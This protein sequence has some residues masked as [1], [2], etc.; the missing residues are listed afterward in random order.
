MLSGVRNLKQAIMPIMW[1]NCIFCMGIFEIP[2]NRP[3][4]FL[5]GFYV[6]FMLTG[7]CI[8]FY[9]TIHILLKEFLHEFSIFY[10]VVAVNILVAILAIIL[11]WKRSENVSCLIKRHSVVDNTLDAL[12]MKTEYQVTY[13]SVLHIIAIWIIGS[14]LMVIATVVWTYDIG[15]VDIICINLVLH[16]PLFINSIVDVTFISF[17]RCIQL[18]FQ[19]TN[20]LINNV[21]LCANESNTFKINRQDNTSIAFVMANYKNHKDKILHLIQTLR[22]L[23]LEIT[24]IGRLTNGAYCILLLLELAVHF[25]VVTATTYCLLCAFSGKLKVAVDNGRIIAMAMMACIYSFKIILVNCI[26]T[27]ISVEAYKTGEIIQSF[28]GSIIDDDMREEIHQFTQQIVLK[29]LTFTA[30]GFFSIDNTLTGK[31]FATVMTYVVILIQMD[32]H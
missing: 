8:L 28:E 10:L 30:T 24:K 7:Y 13:R 22:H 29:P 26:C 6:I 11:F 23:H 1:L 3:R 21:V 12:G 4:Y 14:I 17:I 2:I 20:T 9:N 15:Y 31:F 19:K 25:T 5:S 32:P 16:F 27:N 18:K